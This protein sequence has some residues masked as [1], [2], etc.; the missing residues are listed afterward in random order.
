MRPP[1]TRRVRMGPGGD[2][3]RQAGDQHPW[4]QGLNEDHEQRIRHH[5]RPAWLPVHA[6]RKDQFQ[7][8]NCDCYQ[9]NWDVQG[10]EQMGSL[11]QHGCEHRDGDCKECG[12]PDVGQR[13]L[14][15]WSARWVQRRW[16][17]AMVSTNPASTRWK[18]AGIQAENQAA[19]EGTRVPMTMRA[20]DPAMYMPP[21][22]ARPWPKRR[23]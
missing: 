3:K 18:I 23:L 4:H 20:R 1:G 5:V 16:K 22:Q 8:D 7:S 2:R 19:A 15:C 12:I 11:L 21:N 9:H 6:C 13:A 14:H 10:D 17:W